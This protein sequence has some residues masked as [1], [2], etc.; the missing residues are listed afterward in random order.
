MLRMIVHFVDRSWGLST[1]A[2]YWCW[3][4]WDRTGPLGGKQRIIGCEGQGLWCGKLAPPRLYLPSVSVKDGW[5]GPCDQVLNVLIAYRSYGPGKPSTWPS[6]EGWL[7]SHC[8]N[9]WL[10]RETGY[11][12][13][14]WSAVVLWIESG[15]VA[16]LNSVDDY[17]KGCYAL[18][19]WDTYGQASYTDWAW[20]ACGV[21][22]RFPL[23]GVHRL[24][25]TT[26]K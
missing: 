20:D 2:L 24:D 9:G 23:Q 1:W 8:F 18:T 12:P 21:L 4:T 3:I 15:A 26:W 25:C 14:N 16:L 5:V 11:G 7:C 22:V 13:V 6:I 10:R 17:V 19:A